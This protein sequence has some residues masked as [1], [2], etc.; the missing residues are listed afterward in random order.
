MTRSPIECVCI[1]PFGNEDPQFEEN[2]G[3][4]VGRGHSERATIAHRECLYIAS[5]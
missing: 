3:C 2:F 1:L 4:G 5:G